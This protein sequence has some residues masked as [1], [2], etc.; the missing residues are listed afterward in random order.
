C[1][2]LTSGRTLAFSAP[3]GTT[4]KME[5][6]HEEAH[7]CSRLDRRD[8]RAAVHSDRQ[9]SFGIPVERLIRKQRVLI[10]VGV[11]TLV[12]SCEASHLGGGRPVR[13][14]PTRSFNLASSRRL[15]F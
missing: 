7:R 2:R 10:N 8:R 9:R 12:V 4:E 11:R 15:L 3:A 14:A 13:S 6:C 1:T 5:I